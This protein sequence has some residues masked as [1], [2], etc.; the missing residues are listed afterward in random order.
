[1][2]W[3]N[4]SNILILIF[5]FVGTCGTGFLVWKACQKPK[6]ILRFEDGKKEKTI[7]PH[8]YTETLKYYV[9]PYPEIFQFDKF[10]DLA[11]RYL[12]LHEKDNRFL[13]TFRLSNTGAFQLEN[14]RVEIDY[15]VN[16]CSA[17]QI[18]EHRHGEPFVDF[19]S[20][21]GVSFSKEKP[22]VV[23][24]PVN[25]MFPL[26]QNDYEDYSFQI[27][28]KIEAEEIELNWRI[29]AK[30]FSDNGKFI[31]HLKPTVT[32]FTNIQPVYRACEVPEGAE[33]VEDLTPYI[34]QFEELLKE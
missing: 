18:K 2:S 6:A 13:L 32:H 31:I 22:M 8:Y 7:S 34:K 21:D 30:D 17:Y 26:N 33:T 20:F 1:M 25:V 28:P 11:E 16:Q 19:P 15:D 12:K 9:V 4:I 29:I 10:H 14:Y 3:E 24:A 23:L 5:T 27:T